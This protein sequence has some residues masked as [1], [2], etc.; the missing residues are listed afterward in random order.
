MSIN[1]IEKTCRSNQSKLCGRKKCE[2]CFIRSFASFEGLCPDGIT[3]KVQCWSSKNSDVKPWQVFLKTAKKYWFKCPKCPH[4]FLNGLSDMVSKLRW[5]PYCC[6]INHKLCGSK[7][8]EFCVKKSLYMYKSKI[9]DVLKINCIN[10]KL[11]NGLKPWQITM[12]SDKKIYMDCPK[13]KH[14]FHSCIKSITSGIWCPYCSIQTQKLC[15]N[16]DCKHCFKNSFASC[17]IKKNR[18]NILQYW[19]KDK[20][21]NVTPRNIIKGTHKKYYFKCKECKHSFNISINHIYGGK[22]C[23]YCVNKKLCDN[24]KCKICFN[25][26]FASYKGKTKFNKLVVSLWDYEK[27][28][29]IPRNIFLYS[30]KK[31]YF[32]CSNCNHINLMLITNITR[33]N[34]GC[35]YCSY[36]CKKIC[37]DEKCLKCYNNSL[38]SFLDNNKS[39]LKWDKKK[40]KVHPRNILKGSET[41]YN[42]ICIRCN[43]SHKLIVYSVTGK[44]RHSC[45]NCKNKTEYI[46]N[47]WL[48]ENYKYKIKRE[49]IYDWCKKE[50]RTNYSHLRFDFVIEKLKLIIEV[51]GIQHFEK[52]KY[53]K[54]CPAKIFERDEFKMKCALKQGYSI[55]RVMQ[56]DIYCNRNDWKKKCIKAIKKYDKPQIICIGCENKYKKH[57]S[58]KLEESDD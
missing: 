22:W 20:N 24:D 57:N 6:N 8:C 30:Q 40:N 55:L 31:Y 44:L 58:V 13:C 2:T 18:I 39:L 19:D 5:C 52:V 54:N 21:K 27:N 4:E 38:Q 43:I 29:E 12:K 9:N 16:I 47:T 42:F 49:A 36:P 37:S 1:I 17:K 23:P 33:N 48:T 56:L 34:A 50:N 7:K 3:K 51:D 11:N 45:P 53:F 28:N 10:K 15:E 41:K 32:K 46:F 25:K 14:T 26:S 35:S